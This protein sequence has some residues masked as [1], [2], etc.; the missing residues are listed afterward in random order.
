MIAVFPNFE[1]LSLGHKDI[2]N[3][4]VAKFPPYS[5]FN[6][7]SLHSWNIDN[8]MKVSSLNNNLV[9]WFKDY[10]SKKAFLS[11]IGDTLVDETLRTLL[12]Y[13]LANSLHHELHLIPEHVVKEIK[14]PEKFN[15][16]EDRD[17]HDYIVMALKFSELKGNNYASKR[18]G[19]NNFN[20]NFAGR[21]ELKKLVVD[22]Q[23][24]ND[25][26]N[27]FHKWRQDSDKTH[28]ETENELKAIQRLLNDAQHFNLQVLG[29][30][31]DDTLVAYSIY[32]IADRYA[33]GHFE[34]A[35]K[36]HPGLYDYLK[37]QTAMNLHRQGVKY[38]NYEQ[39]LGI[40][41]LRKTKL[42]LHP[43][44]FLKKY[45]VSYK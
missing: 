40:E 11:F 25:I 13:A 26:N 28:Q 35:L 17:A 4:L 5:D 34:K 9:V 22:D 37:H 19:I 38:I 12:D 36:T 20:A 16:K 41:G 32:E 44:H 42:L 18:H 3:K 15:I 39:D 33:I 6:F 27:I 24:V 45:T 21:V 7:V 10:T 31:M 1:P 29:V 8:S 30:Y 43:E 23:A 2:V 14:R